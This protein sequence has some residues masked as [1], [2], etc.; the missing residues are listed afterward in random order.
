MFR[1]VLQN[2]TTEIVKKKN[3]A[4]DNF[5]NFGFFCNCL[6]KKCEFSAMEMVLGI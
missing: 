6:I 2:E 4:K 1:W 3:S 5:D